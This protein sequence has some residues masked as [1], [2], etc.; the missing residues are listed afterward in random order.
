MQDA[1]RLQRG[2]FRLAGRFKLPA[3]LMLQ[4]MEQ[5]QQ[6]G[7]L[8]VGVMAVQPIE[9][10][11]HRQAAGQMRTNSG[12]VHLLQQ[13]HGIAGFILWKGYRLWLVLARGSSARE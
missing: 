8:Q 4:V 10:I 9:Q 12:F 1:N 7:I 2:F 11:F 6:G 5:A 3:G 13:L